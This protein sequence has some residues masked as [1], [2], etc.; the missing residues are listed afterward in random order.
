MNRESIEELLRQTLEDGKVSRS[1]RAVLRSVLQTEATEPHDR[2]WIRN[3]AMEIAKAKVIT[4]D[5]AHALA[6]LEDVIGLLLTEER[7]AQPVATVA[8]AHFSPGDHC[9][10]RIRELIRQCRSGL[11]ICVFTITDDRITRSILEAHERKVRVR[12]ISDNDKAMD[13]GSD[14]RRLTEQGVPVALDR[15]SDHMHHKFALFDNRIV[16]SGSYNWTRSAAD[17][18]EENI[19]ISDDRRLLA[20]FRSRFDGLW[21]ELSG[22]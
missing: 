21:S 8:E 9:L 18:N 16:V 1:E 7:S 19:V 10:V 20:S 15:V 14:V 2:D 22:D 11:D 5:G 13:L 17:R 6:W 12:I 4:P 3:R